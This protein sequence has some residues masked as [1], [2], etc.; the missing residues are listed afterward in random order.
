MEV[1]GVAFMLVDLILFFFFILIY[2]WGL[3]ELERIFIY[4]W[5]L[6]FYEK[7]SGV[8]GCFGIFGSDFEI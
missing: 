3:R 2:C 8:D 5:C 1:R 6:I 7:Y 4:D